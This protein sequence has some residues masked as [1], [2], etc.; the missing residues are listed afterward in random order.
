M[1][2]A[3]RNRFPAVMR[4]DSLAISTS[5]ERL[6]LKVLHLTLSFARGGR[7]RA[8]ATLSR[9]LRRAGVQ[10]DLCCLEAAGCPEAEVDE[11]ADAHLVLRRRSLLDQRALGLL[12]EFCR[13]RGVRIIHAHDAAS[14]F[15]A[16]CLRLRMP[17]L[18]LLMTFH[19][20][21]SFESATCRARLRNS[22]GCW[23]SQAVVT[24]S[25]ERRDHF[26]SQNWVSAQ[27]LRVIPWGI[28]VQG[29][30]PDAEARQAIRRE[31][32]IEDDVVLIGAVGHLYEEKGI[33]IVIQGFHVLRRLHP[34]LPVALAI[35]GDGTLERR[36]RIGRLVQETAPGR[37]HLAG[38]QTD[39]QRWFAA[40][41]VL[42]HAPR[43]EAFGLVLLEAMASGLPIVASRVGG[44]PEI[45][46]HGQ[47]GFLVAPESPH[48]L[49]E[50]LSRLLINPRLRAALGRRGRALA[51]AEYAA[52][53]CTQRHIQLYEALLA[54]QSSRLA[55]A[56]PRARAGI[57][58]FAVSSSEH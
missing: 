48:D 58:P 54:R 21:L 47:T 10:S 8:I 27:K 29:F 7:R 3:S 24:A 38:Y 22:L 19:R 4:D 31:L 11:V 41:D 57:R 15:T 56:G 14:Q 49:A 34:D 20:S 44:I 45:V 1:A 9:E 43:T 18:R 6:L 5:A 42:A 36:E 32:K 55:V 25:Q 13:E 26:L 39:V 23:L 2:W 12:G 40:F 33:D 52:E 37:I 53:T 16:A 30:Q 50:G 17:S 28:D 46:R 51:E 35:V